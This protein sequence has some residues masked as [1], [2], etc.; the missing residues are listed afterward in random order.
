MS[1]LQFIIL[2]MLCLIILFREDRSLPVTSEGSLYIAPV[3]IVSPWMS[4]TPEAIDC[5]G[6]VGKSGLEMTASHILFTSTK[7]S[8]HMTIPTS[9][10][11]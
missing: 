7:W 1:S 4:L 11:S 3:K 8:P 9:G 6:S 2:V 10:F 5:R